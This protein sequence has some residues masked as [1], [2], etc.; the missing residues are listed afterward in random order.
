MLLNQ[1]GMKIRL[2]PFLKITISANVFL[3]FAF[4][5]L[6]LQAQISIP[7]V[8]GSQKSRV[9]QWMGITEVSITYSSPSVTSPTGE[10]RRGEI[11]GKRIPYGLT[12]ERWL[13]NDGETITPKPWRGGANEN[14]V[15]TVSHDVIIEG[16]RLPAGAY[17]LFFIPGEK[18]WE[19]ILSEDSKSWGHYFYNDKN[20]ALR[21]KVIPEKSDYH[22][23][24][25]YEFAEK[26]VDSSTLVLFWEDLKVPIHMSVIDIH[27]VYIGQMKE[28]LA[29]RKMF[30]W[31]NW[32]GA[33]KYCLDNNVE[34]ELGLRWA[35][36][37]IDQPYIGNTNFATLKTKAELLLA[38][39]RKHEADSIIQFAIKYT[40]GVFELHNYG[41]ELLQ[42]KE[43]DEAFKIFKLNA[44]KYP[45]YWVTQLGLARAYGAQGDYKAALKYAYSAKKMIP[46]RELEIKHIS[47]YVLIDQLEQ[48]KI[49]DIYLDKNL[50]QAY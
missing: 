1:F 37:A 6:K 30:Y 32:H 9:S 50:F 23:W 24:L 38:L 27:H 10:N 39:N 19:L 25:T 43:V 40:G 28:E 48:K 12:E 13:E 47:I 31:Y 3:L 36:K 33:G 22:E 8:G 46:K 29:S 49:P 11:W 35:E 44:T 42:K 20:D 5:A 14:T 34:L 15:L 26:K 4:F 21:V 17:G 2:A 16:Q 18:E 45:D 41:R 7:P